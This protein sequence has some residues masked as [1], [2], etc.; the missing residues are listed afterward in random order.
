MAIE[1]FFLGMFLIF[2]LAVLAELGMC[3]YAIW[4]GPE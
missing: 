2:T 4:R 3:L 1:V